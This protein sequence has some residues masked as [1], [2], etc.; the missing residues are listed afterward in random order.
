[1]NLLASNLINATI[2]NSESENEKATVHDVFIDLEEQKLAYVT[3]KLYK[4]PH[5]MDEQESKS[6]LEKINPL[7]NKDKKSKQ[8]Y[9]IPEYK[10]ETIKPGKLT[11]SGQKI[12]EERR[13][14]SP[15]CH[16]HT[17]LQEIPI[18][19]ETGE[20]LG[21]L[22]EI[23]L[24]TND[25]TIIGLM[26]EEEQNKP[27]LPCEDVVSWNEDKIIVASGAQLKLLDHLEQLR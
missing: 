15:N 25:K 23:I 7:D 17:K 22:E 6:F 26:L 19:S 20:Q 18:V 8:L 5:E 4:P 2:T 14:P 13:E 24:N 27:Y 12:E 1:M 3:L 16:S 11:M 9:Y 21:E 10:I